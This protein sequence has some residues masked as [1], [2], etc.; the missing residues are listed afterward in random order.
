MYVSVVFNTDNSVDIPHF[1][2]PII[3]N[4]SLRFT[5]II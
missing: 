2:K 4:E 3:L 1:T 5:K